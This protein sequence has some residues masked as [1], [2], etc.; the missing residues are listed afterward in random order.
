MKTVRKKNFDKSSTG[1]D[2][3]ISC[4]YDADLSSMY[5]GENIEILQHSGY[6]T[7]SI[8]YF[9]GQGDKSDT[10]K[11]TI[12]GT[13]AAIIAAARRYTSAYSD[14]VAASG[15]ELEDIKA[16]I[17]GQ[18]E[19]IDLI[20]FALDKLPEIEG[21]E[22]VPNKNLITIK[23]SGYSQGDYAVVVY[24]PEDIEKCWGTYPKQESI[25]K[26]VD[27]LYW[28]AP[29]YCRFTINEKE[30]D[31]YDMPEADSY[32]WEREMFIECVSKESGVSKETLENFVPE[33][34]EYN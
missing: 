22:I 6:S 12:K 27:N 30:Y 15:K 20:H 11:M 21:L 7:T 24:C 16:E 31:Y 34:P 19:G 29:I 1:T 9:H 8:G 10:V 23:T 5:F 4:S 25:Q 33:Y 26:M 17:I 14:I 28:G 3:E 18:F 13:T 32:K 2:I